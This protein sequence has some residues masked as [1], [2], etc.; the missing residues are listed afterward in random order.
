[1]E[2]LKRA[3]WASSW[4]RKQKVQGLSVHNTV[5]VSK[6]LVKGHEIEIVSV[7]RLYFQCNISGIL[8]WKI[9]VLNLFCNYIRAEGT[10]EKVAFWGLMH[11]PAL[12]LLFHCLCYQQ[13][14]SVIYSI[15]SWST[16]WEIKRHL[17]LGRKA[18]TQT[19]TL[20]CQQRSVKA[21]VF[22]V[23]MYG[24]ESWTIKKAE[25]QRIDAFELWFWKRLLRVPWT[26]R[27]SKQSIL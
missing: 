24:C 10:R 7:F 2:N 9:R 18:M 23:V 8:R 6:I 12:L 17:L 3:P 26:A 16:F 20:P 5:N 14:S 22:P 21:M 11:L 25:H 13:L 27:R 19:E 4:E 1:M 15:L